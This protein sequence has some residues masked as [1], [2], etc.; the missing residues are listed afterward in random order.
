MSAD[1]IEVW[2]VVEGKEPSHGGDA[3]SS[4]DPWSGEP[5][6]S[7]HPADRADVE[8]A[9]AAARGGFERWGAMSWTARGDLLA[10][11]AGVVRERADGLAD[12]AVR[13]VGKPVVE[14]RGEVERTARIF[15]FY[16]QETRRA[17]GAIVPADEPGVA[18]LTRR[19]PLG[20]V[21]L[22]TPWNFPFAIPAWKM[23]PALACGNAVMW[24]PASAAVACAQA[25]TRCV[26]DAGVPADVL[27]LI[28]GGGA[29]GE[30]LVDQPVAGLS[31]TGSTSVGHRLRERVAPRGV[32]VQLELGGKNVAVVLD[33]VE[34]PAAVAALLAR[35]AFGYA[36]QKC[37][38]T[39]LVLAEAGV[40]DQLQEALAGETEGLPWGDP[41]DDAVVGGPVISEEQ[42][43]FVREQLADSERAGAEVLARGQVASR[44]ESVVEPTLVSA[45]SGEE[46]VAR[47][48][49]FGPVL[50]VLPDRGAR[51]LSEL[52]NAR[53]YGLVASIFGRDLDRV[54]ELTNSLEVGVIA[55][56]RLST[57]LEVQAPFGGWKASGSSDPEQGTEAINFYTRSQTVYWKSEGSE[58]P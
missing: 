34:N 31:F 17:K 1:A 24:K 15:E 27:S 28:V 12:L 30:A 8:R 41:A 29:V 5:V 14:A 54:R 42:G 51:S 36:G 18:V 40:R 50:T 58:W 13:E 47:E 45:A 7:A 56:N 48:E 16:A 43:R 37:T 11:V 10:R 4:D 21:V 26:L 52:A 9:A 19:R 3:F 38:A 46:L 25:V 23:A 55:I 57:G 35:A 39:S 6:A 22:I 44:R 49:V 32:R 20:P 53:D 2:S 33:D